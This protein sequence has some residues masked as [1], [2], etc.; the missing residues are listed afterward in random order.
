MTRIRIG[1][2][3]RDLNDVNP[4]WI[5]EHLSPYQNAGQA[6]CVKVSIHSGDVN[7]ALS[8]P[9]CGGGGGSG[10]LPNSREQ[11]ILDLWRKRGL[12]SDDFNFGQLNAFLNEIKG[13]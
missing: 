10:R 1:T 5:R 12:N 7:V 2:S 8:T 13:L 6:V 4:T 9:A 11:A 3:E